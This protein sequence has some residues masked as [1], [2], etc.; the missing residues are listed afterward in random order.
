[1]E[2]PGDA[3]FHRSTM[4]TSD[5]TRR[6]PAYGQCYSFSYSPNLRDKQINN[7]YQRRAVESQWA[8]NCNP[9]QNAY[10]S[11]VLQFCEKQGEILTNKS[12]FI[13]LMG[14]DL[15]FP[16]KCVPAC[17]IFSPFASIKLNL[18]AMPCCDLKL[19]VSN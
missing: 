19:G 17:L 6:R 15:F 1:M 2:N 4:Y 12:P 13:S 10:Q 18:V 5:S 8:A 16:H 7:G 14:N 11:C 9:G 3:A